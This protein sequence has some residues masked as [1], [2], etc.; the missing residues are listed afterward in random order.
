MSRRW[1]R[2]IQSNPEITEPILTDDVQPEL[3]N[4][5]ALNALDNLC[6]YDGVV[7]GYDL[8]TAILCLFIEC[9]HI[10]GAFGVTS[11]KLKKEVDTHIDCPPEDFDA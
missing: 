9:I 6:V 1:N 4:L 3:C 11:D 7:K 5:F 2:T 10:L 8:N